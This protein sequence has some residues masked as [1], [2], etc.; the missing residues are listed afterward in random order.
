MLKKLRC[1]Q[2][3]QNLSLL[4]ISVG[5]SLLVMELAL[6]RIVP[7]D[8]GTSFQHRVP[9]PTLG[10]VLEPGASYSNRL[11]ETTVRVQYNS[12]GWRD[13]EREF[14]P[15]KDTF[16]ILVLGDSFME[17]YSV[18]FADSFHQQLEALAR[19]RG[20]AVEVI[21][22]GVGGYGTLQA[23]LAWHEVGRLYEPDLIL[24]GFYLHNDV[25]NN[26]LELEALAVPSAQNLKLAS[27]PFLDPD[28][29]NRW[30][31]TLVDF[32]NAQRRYLE[33]QQQQKSIS[34]QLARRSALVRI[35]ARIAQEIPWPSFW[36]S[37]PAET[38]RP[39]EEKANETPSPAQRDLAL[40]GIHYCQQPTEYD[41][42]WSITE[43]I[44]VRLQRE[45]KAAG[46]QLAIFSVPDL[47]EVDLKEIKQA[48]DRS[49]DEQ[50]VCL[51]EGKAHQD[52]EASLRRLN[53]EFINLLPAFRQTTQ[54]QE[55]DLFWFSDR[56][57]NPQGHALAAEEVFEA[58]QERELLPA[59]ATPNTT[60][61]TNPPAGQP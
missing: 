22:L 10:W 7:I 5:V 27:R 35:A 11:S 25:R 47:V 42:A 20:H 19:D 16:R 56:H 6:R 49:P 53:I 14:T 40:Q 60:P 39:S 44:L 41:R 33:A 1:K 3:L 37:D 29:P 57:W 51:T 43:R 38:K 48:E 8:L 50:P 12:Q 2:L 24:L 36:E 58:L 30:S 59:I 9:H 21:N 31:V 34:N 17:G 23:Y 54:Q 61:P 45:A 32:E 55:I 13:L 18:N 46:S 28:Q 4:A 15:A 52:L 26:S